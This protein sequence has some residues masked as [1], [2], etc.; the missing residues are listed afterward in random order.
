MRALA[1]ALT[2]TL[3]LS[4]GCLTRVGD[5]TAV[6]NHSIDSPDPIA[7]GV[8]GEDCIIIWQAG[9]MPSLEKAIDNAVRSVPAANALVNVE[10]D[11]YLNP[12]GAFLWARACYKVRAD[13]VAI[14]SVK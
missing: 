9:Q 12:F 8:F 13:A 7:R 3:S 1:T 11:Y 6:A 4:L 2:L 14:K 5:L 10:I